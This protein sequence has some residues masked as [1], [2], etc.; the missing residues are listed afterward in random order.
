MVLQLGG[1]ATVKKLLCRK[2]EGLDRRALGK[3]ANSICRKIRFI[4]I[5]A[6]FEVA[7][8]DEVVLQG[9]HVFLKVSNTALRLNHGGL[10]RRSGLLQIAIELLVVD[11][12]AD[13]SLARVNLGAHR[14]QM[15]R[16]RSRTGHGELAAIQNGV[17]LVEHVSHHQRRFTAD[18]LPI[19]HFGL[20]R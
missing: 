7:A 17:R 8:Q 20:A 1:I 2:R 10:Q 13:G 6:L 12:C 5:S 15:G 18:D 14:V 9:L 19:L 11:K 3:S 4:F 16:C